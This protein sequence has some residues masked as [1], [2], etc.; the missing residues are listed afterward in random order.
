[1]KKLLLNTALLLG[2]ASASLAQSFTFTTTS[3]TYTG[4][5]AP[6]SGDGAFYSFQAGNYAPVFY[7]DNTCT[8]PGDISG[9]T[10]ADQLGG[11]DP[12]VYDASTA[13]PARTGTIFY[14]GA[15]RNTYNT[16]ATVCTKNTPSFGFTFNNNRTIDMSTAGDQKLAF[17]YTNNTGTNLTVEIQ[18]FDKPN[19]NG[20]LNTLSY[21]FLA[22]A[23]NHNVV[24]DLS[25]YVAGGADMTNIAQVSFTYPYDTKS[26]N[27]GL[28]FANITIGGNTAPTLASS[29][30][31]SSNLY[32][33]PVSD[34]A[35]VELNLAAPS[36]VKVAVYDVMGKEVMT[37]ANGNFFEL[38]QEFSVAGLNKGVYNVVYYVNGKAAKAD[39]LMVK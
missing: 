24:L 22:D 35:T 5:G 11:F 36:E 31:S 33:N 32:P 14:G 15:I 37:I 6:A 29:S 7:I 1:M 12:N 34:V 27:F 3:A 28:S 20:K 19:Y 23:T 10:G 38:K 30:V 26:P 8:T 21:T 13:T 18:L 17:S 9:G 4:S 39:R 2:V 25:S 16:V